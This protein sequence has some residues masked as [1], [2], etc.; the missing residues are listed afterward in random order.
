M[1]ILI[2]SAF[3]DLVV[4]LKIE[5]CPKTCRNFLRLARMKYYNQQPIHTVAKGFVASVGAGHSRLEDLETGVNPTGSAGWVRGLEAVKKRKTGRKRSV[6]KLVVS[7]RR[8]NEINT[9]TRSL[10]C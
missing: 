7:Y 1:S 2:E 4:D 10:G 8:M 9:P 3:G 6:K 5:E